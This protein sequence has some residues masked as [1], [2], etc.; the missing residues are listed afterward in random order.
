MDKLEEQASA[1]E[2]LNKAGEQRELLIEELRKEIKK[3]R[4]TARQ[5]FEMFAEEMKTKSMEDEFRIKTLAIEKSRM[6]SEMHIYKFYEQENA[7]LR[8]IVKNLHN[9]LEKISHIKT[10]ESQTAT[11]ELDKWRKQIE[12]VS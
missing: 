3:L 7:E 9:Q 11:I 2:Y 12:L 1:I 5:E 8:S 6:E 10:V 4:V